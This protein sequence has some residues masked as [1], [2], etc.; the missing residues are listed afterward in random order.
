MTAVEQRQAVPYGPMAGVVARMRA[1]HAGL[2]S[3]DGVA[4]FNRMY[5][6]VTVELARRL[7]AGGFTAREAS[8]DLAVRF[9]DRY[10][11]AVEG[12]FDHGCGPACWRPLFRSRGHPG[13]RP[14]QFAL[15]GI[16][17]HI[18]HDLALA[19]LDTCRARGAR[20]ALLERDFD[21][22]GEVL[23]EL[24]EAVREELMPGPDLL[25]VADPLTH[26]VGAWS[27]DRARDGAWVAF[28]SMWGLRRFPDLTEEFAE[29]LDAAVGLAGR[30]LVTPLDVRV[31]RG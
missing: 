2:P 22:V 9:A 17:A 8:A 25:E 19:L 24:E 27:L 26:L 31:R 21:R 16:N 23:A 15:A 3:H 6:R 18:G 30:C 10:L 13:V 14:V 28:R 5:L 7:E 29:R 1:V 4:V 12:F 20:P 11:R